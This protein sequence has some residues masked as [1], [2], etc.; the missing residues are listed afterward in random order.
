M[1]DPA[2][3]KPR[4]AGHPGQF[5]K[6]HWRIEVGVDIIKRFVDP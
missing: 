5:F 3:V 2:E 1:K 6:G 4:E